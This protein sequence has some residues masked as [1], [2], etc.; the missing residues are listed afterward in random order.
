MNVCLPCPGPLNR[1]L[2][3]TRGIL[4]L[5]QPYSHAQTFFLLAARH[6]LEPL[7]YT[8][9]EEYEYGGMRNPERWKS[10]SRVIFG[11]S[12]TGVAQIH[13]VLASELANTGNPLA[14]KADILLIHRNGRDCGVLE[15]GTSKSAK[16]RQVILRVEKLQTLMLAA[17]R[18]RKLLRGVTWRP[19]PWRPRWPKGCRASEPF[20]DKYVCAEPTWRENAPPGVLLYEVHKLKREDVRVPTLYSFAAYPVAEYIR[21]WLKREGKTP[22]NLLASEF[23]AEAARRIATEVRF[24]RLLNWHVLGLGSL[25][26]AS[27]IASLLLVESG[28]ADIVLIE[29]TRRFVQLAIASAAL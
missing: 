26:I 12:A 23:Q 18:S 7:G 13:E 9:H 19:F 20:L 29:S 1:E 8:V 10:K 15:V 22:K 24:R 6:E 27:G 21:E 25:A 5:D 14:G 16:T 28:P 3:A 2:A 4:A 17:S 11:A